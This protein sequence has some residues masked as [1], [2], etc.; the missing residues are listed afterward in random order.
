MKAHLLTSRSPFQFAEDPTAKPATQKVVLKGVAIAECGPAKGHFAVWDK[1]K[2]RQVRE[3]DTEDSLVQ[4]VCD[5]GTLQSIVD[6][7]EGRNIKLML[8]HD[9]AVETVAGKFTNFRIDGDAVRA[10]L[11]IFDSSPHR[12]W[13]LELAEECP[14]SVGISMNFDIE[15]QGDSSGF[16]LCRVRNLS[17]CDLV[18][19]PAATSGLF[20]EPLAMSKVPPAQKND[21]RRFV[22]AHSNPATD[23]D[24]VKFEDGEDG[25]EAA[26]TME[27]LTAELEALKELIVSLQAQIDKPEEDAE[28]ETAELDEGGEDKKD[29]T[30]KPEDKDEE[31]KT[32][33]LDESKMS[34]RDH[35]LVQATAR[36][37]AG[38][39]SKTFASSRGVR[40]SVGDNPE[41][42]TAAMEFEAH[43][44]HVQRTKGITQLEASRAVQIKNPEKYSTYRDSLRR[45]K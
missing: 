2:F 17:S 19:R 24:P 35:A 4:I 30:D 9:E 26:V 25:E 15:L 12:D 37:V 34:A 18:T 29:D 41:D 43:V 33:T 31:P 27:S 20:N 45:K 6:A 10:D 3:D 11:T 23:P 5:Q 38:E 7:A 16:A 1:G 32:E 40:P 36:A 42:P 39:F 8:N 22:G 28:E 14:D 13:L 21:R 44:M